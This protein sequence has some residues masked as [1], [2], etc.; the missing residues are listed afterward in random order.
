MKHISKTDNFAT[1]LFVSLLFSSPS[2]RRKQRKEGGGYRGAVQKL[3]YWDLLIK[4]TIF[5]LNI[6]LVW[7]MQLMIV[8]G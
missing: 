2:L 8:K 6:D 7:R 4:D 5:I 3:S 1:A